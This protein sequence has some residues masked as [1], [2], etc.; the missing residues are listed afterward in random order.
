[1]LNIITKYNNLIVCTVEITLLKYTN[2]VVQ[3]HFDS[4]VTGS[5]RSLGKT[6]TVGT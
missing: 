4:F 3:S 1:L 5:E 6:K 2:A